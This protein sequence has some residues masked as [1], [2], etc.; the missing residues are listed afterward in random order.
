ML[1]EGWGE[2]AYMGLDLSRDFID[3]SRSKFP[4]NSYICG[5]V[6]AEPE[7]LPDFDYAVMNGVFTEKREMSQEDMVAYFERLVE[8]VWK[9]ARA[10]IA[11][12]LMSKHVDWERDDLFHVSYDALAAFLTERLTRRHVIRSDYGLYEYTVYVLKEGVRWP[13]W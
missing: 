13:G 4:D 9:S 7:L 8:A 1:A 10:G 6:L 11:F 5:D 3:L 12:N 2:V